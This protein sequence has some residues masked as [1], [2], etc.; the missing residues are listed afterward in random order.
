MHRKSILHSFI[1]YLFCSAQVI[2]Q[3]LP[4][5]VLLSAG[6][7]AEIESQV[8]SQTRKLFIHHPI[9]SK[10]TEKATS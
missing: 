8:L 7:A 10:L 9:S 3:Q 2:G 4:D 1:L 6:K 5:S